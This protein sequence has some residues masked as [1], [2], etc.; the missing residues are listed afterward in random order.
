[1]CYSL[2]MTKLTAPRA[3]AAFIARRVIRFSTIVAV[4]TIV[5]VGVICLVLAHF[6]SMWWWLLEIPFVLLFVIFLFIR[7][8][9]VLLVNSIHRQKL[10]SKQRAALNDFVDKIQATLEAK[11]MPL[12]L[13]VLICI[14][15]I[16]FHRDVTT[17]KKLIRDTSGLQRDYS[18]LEKLF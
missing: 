8:V 11:S 2:K 6:F 12:S 16:M 14:K 18:E 15:D 3:L 4:L 10:T 5:V 1:M 9:A 13:I 7:L 17:I